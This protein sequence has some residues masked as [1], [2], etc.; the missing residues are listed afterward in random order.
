MHTPNLAMLQCVMLQGTGRR[1]GD[2]MTSD[3]GACSGTGWV[4]YCDIYVAAAFD[5][6][7][8]AGLPIGIKLLQHICTTVI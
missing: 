3:C 2:V 5:P 8:I 7:P 4:Q 1:E 6:Q